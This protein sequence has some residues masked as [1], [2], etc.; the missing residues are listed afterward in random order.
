MFV[1]ITRSAGAVLLVG[2]ALL[3]GTPDARAQMMSSEDAFQQASDQCQNLPKGQRSFCMINAYNH[4]KI[5]SAAEMKQDT[6][7]HVDANKT[8]D[9][10]SDL[11]AKESFNAEA[12]R[13]ASLSKGQRSFCMINAE[14]DFRKGMG[15]KN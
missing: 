11:N 10:P 5:D 8:N 13:C 4:Y 14:N 2:S 6:V 9:T 15:W 12:A 1:S 3:L 7:I